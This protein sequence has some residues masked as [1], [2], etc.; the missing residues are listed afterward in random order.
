MSLPKI[1]DLTLAHFLRLL[2]PLFDLVFVYKPGKVKR[3]ENSW[4]L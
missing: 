1:I 2:L 4:K 3:R